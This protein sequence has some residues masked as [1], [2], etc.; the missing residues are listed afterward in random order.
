[1][2]VYELSSPSW[3]VDPQATAEYHRYCFEGITCYS[4]TFN[5]SG[6]GAG[7]TIA[8]RIIYFKKGNE[9]WGTPQLVTGIMDK[10]VSEQNVK[11]YPNPAANNLTI[12]VIKFSD[13][14]TYEISDIKGRL[15]Q[16]GNF[17]TI[18]DIQH[19]NKGIYSL[20]LNG[21]KRSEILRFV[22]I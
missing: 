9:T 1:M 13:Y 18:L 5:N 2:C 8:P 22:K 12:Q 10:E 16:N 14:N 21:P 15:I 11:I 6:G 7:I 20:K 4:I 3:I 17:Q 19:L